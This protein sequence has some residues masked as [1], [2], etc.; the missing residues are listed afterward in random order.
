MSTVLYAIKA[1]IDDGSA[2]T[3]PVDAPY[4]EHLL[5][6][7]IKTTECPQFAL[8]F[9][10]RQDAEYA[11]SA[12]WTCTLQWR[13]HVVPLRAR[14]ARARDIADLRAD[15]FRAFRLIDHDQRVVMVRVKG[16]GHG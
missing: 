5:P 9:R 8:I 15:G 6:V 11:A 1:Y 7:G 10:T 2:Q 13:G 3:P 14:R 4:F 12:L 16:V